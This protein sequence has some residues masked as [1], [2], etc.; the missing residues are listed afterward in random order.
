MRRHTTYNT[1]GHVRAKPD[2]RLGTFLVNGWTNKVEYYGGIN[3]RFDWWGGWDPSDAMHGCVE[4]AI[5]DSTC[6]G[7]EFSNGLHCIPVNYIEPDDGVSAALLSPLPLLFPLIFKH[8]LLAPL[9]LLDP[10]L[11]A[12]LYRFAPV[13]R[14][15]GRIR[16]TRAMLRRIAGPRGGALRML[17]QRPGGESW[18]DDSHTQ[19]N[20]IGLDRGSMDLI[21]SRLIARFAL[22]L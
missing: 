14:Q 12:D 4:R 20:N 22:R 2:E 7:I 21:Q 10:D 8:P 13:E 15:L 19:E 6:H 11:C 5:Q 1:R 18:M 9:G 16:D 17:G 3:A